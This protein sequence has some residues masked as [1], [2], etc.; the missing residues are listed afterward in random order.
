MDALALLP[1]LELD[2]AAVGQPLATHLRRRRPSIGRQR[3]DKSQISNPSRPI[4]ASPAKKARH[5]RTASVGEGRREIS[6]APL[7][8]RLAKGSQKPIVRIVQFAPN[9]FGR[10][11]KQR[12]RRLLGRHRP[13][14]PF[15][16]SQ[17][18]PSRVAPVPGSS[19]CNTPPP[20]LRGRGA[21]SLHHS[22]GF[23]SR[24]T[25]IF[26]TCSSAS[27]PAASSRRA[28]ARGEER[29]A[30]STFT[31]SMKASQKYSEWPTTWP[32]WRMG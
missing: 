15:A 21:R 24:R 26:S 10:R 6:G 19:L 31:A 2:F 1:A 7:L 32:L 16:H 14:F 4:P 27:P 9:S 3:R 17:S 28:K 8:G 12:C 11:M 22:S 25:T 23:L 30:S 13:R 18:L 5:R 29:T 20:D